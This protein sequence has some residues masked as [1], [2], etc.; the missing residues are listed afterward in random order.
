MASFDR[1]IPLQLHH[2]TARGSPL[3]PNPQAS[4]PTRSGTLPTN[5]PCWLLTKHPQLSNHAPEPAT[6]SRT[7]INRFLKIFPDVPLGQTDPQSQSP[8]APTLTSLAFQP[9]A[10]RVMRS[11][12]RGA[13][14][15]LKSSVYQFFPEGATP[16]TLRASTFFFV[17]SSL[18][19]TASNIRSASSRLMRLGCD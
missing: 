19:W 6:S 7:Y 18:L 17:L 14:T 8:N 13:A 11:I 1:S 3:Q 15:D 12:L 10:I 16:R 5:S 4:R 2:P 9:L